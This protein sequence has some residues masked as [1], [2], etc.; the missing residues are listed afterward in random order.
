MTISAAEELRS[1]DVLERNYE[2]YRDLSLALKER[3][4]QIKGGADFDPDCKATMDAL[5]KQS[6]ALQTVLDLE[7]SLA[8]RT[9]IWGDAG[10]GGAELDLAA[11]RAEIARRL[12]AWSGEG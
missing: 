6:K 5:Q 3:I 11:A 4:A 2:M 1:A 9:R 10:N 7:A 8:K 12:A